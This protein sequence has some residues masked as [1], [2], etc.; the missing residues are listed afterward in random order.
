M[1][2]SYGRHFV[3]T[4]WDR[5]LPL[6]LTSVGLVEHQS[7][8]DREQ[9]FGS[10]HWLHTVEGCGQFTVNGTT[11]KLLP[12]EGILMRTGTPHSYWPDSERWTTWYM[13]FDGALANPIAASLELP[14]SQPLSWSDDCPLA[15]IH[16]QYGEKFGY[17]FD[18][19]GVNGSLEVYSFLALLKKYGQSSGQPSLS[20]GHERLKPIYL[21]I[22]ERYGDPTL[23]LD[24]MAQV[25][26]I[27]P[28]YLNKLFRTNWGISP[29]QYLVQFRIQKSK[30]LLLADRNRTVKEIAA[31]VGFQDDSHFVHTFRKLS[32]TTPVQF[33]S[34]FGK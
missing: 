22:E 20:K 10:Y 15:F 7:P 24:R 25:L 27:S 34:L 2:T 30:E 21:L 28:Q 26:D 23:G 16:E 33:R 6:H 3:T 19:A 11:T 14:M 31:D 29:Y 4:E 32:G 5:A 17:S 9:G 13:T 8:I 18:F 12:N 1:S